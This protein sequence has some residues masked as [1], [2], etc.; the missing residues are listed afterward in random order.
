MKT[1]QLKINGQNA[2]PCDC[3]RAVW[4]EE[5]DLWVCDDPNHSKN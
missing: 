4:I 5:L 3:D 2:Y 1:E